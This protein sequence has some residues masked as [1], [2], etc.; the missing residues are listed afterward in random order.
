MMNYM[1]SDML[2]LGVIAYMDDV[3]IYDKT[4]EGHDKMVHEV[5]RRL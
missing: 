4:E 1:F 3:L 2:D 5:L